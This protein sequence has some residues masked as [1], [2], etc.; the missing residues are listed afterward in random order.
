MTSILSTIAQNPAQNKERIKFKIANDFK[1]IWLNRLH[2][3][4]VSFVLRTLYCYSF[5]LRRF[6]KCLKDGAVA[7]KT[8]KCVVIMFAL[9]DPVV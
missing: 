5:S 9:T 7:A 2:I 1:V 3:K 4:I 8:I 6:S